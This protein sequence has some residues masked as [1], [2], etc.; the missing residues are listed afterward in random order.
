MNTWP[1]S[2]VCLL[3]PSLSPIWSR[4]PA[5]L[6]SGG[7]M[8]HTTLLSV[9]AKLPQAQQTLLDLAGD[10]L[11]RCRSPGWTACS[12]RAHCCVCVRHMSSNLLAAVCR[13]PGH[14][15]STSHDVSSHHVHMVAS[16]AAR[17]STSILPLPKPLLPSL[18]GKPLATCGRRGHGTSLRGTVS[19]SLS[20]I[21]AKGKYDRH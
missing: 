19:P 9:M 11:S 18:S 1:Q 3:L 7:A 8:G 12:L 4:K 14:P 5:G 20:A 21:N 15:R 10:H 2:R 17:A 16:L 13:S 6:S